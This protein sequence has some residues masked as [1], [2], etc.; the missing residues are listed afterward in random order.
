MTDPLQTLED[1]FKWITGYARNL[2]HIGVQYDLVPHGINEIGT[3]T[4][5]T[6]R[7]D[8]FVRFNDG[9]EWTF[10]RSKKA[11]ADEEA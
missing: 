2:P 8:I 11:D 6:D 7:V 9:T 4:S 10:A 3:I 1:C 5:G